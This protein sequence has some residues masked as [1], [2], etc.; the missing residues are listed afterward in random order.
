M[1]IVK[2]MF[3]FT[4]KIT[5]QTELET[6]QDGLSS[7]TQYY[8]LPIHIKQI[9]AYIWIDEHFHFSL[10]IK[11]PLTKPITQNHILKGETYCLYLC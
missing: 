11:Q 6:F 8:R 7:Y 4:K 2:D 1:I 3:L 9:K 10:Q 5:Q